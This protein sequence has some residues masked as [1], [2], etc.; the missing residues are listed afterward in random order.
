MYI[1]VYA[2]QFLLVTLETRACPTTAVWTA[3]PSATACDVAAGTRISSERASAVR[4]GVDLLTSSCWNINVCNFNS[5]QCAFLIYMYYVHVHVDVH[6]TCRC[7]CTCIHVC[8]YRLD[9][10]VH[11]DVHVH[12]AYMLNSWTQDAYLLWDHDHSHSPVLKIALNA[13]CRPNDVCADVS[14]TCRR[15]QCLCLD[16]FFDRN[17]QCCKCRS[18]WRHLIVVNLYCRSLI[19]NGH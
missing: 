8:T 6:V 13:A 1:W 12:E 19:Q 10:H 9:V 3:T 11:V 14:A 2:L 18:L 17:G 5:Q 16:G 15:G 7:A 4:L